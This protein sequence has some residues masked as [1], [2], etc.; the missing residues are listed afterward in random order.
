MTSHAVAATRGRSG[1]DGE[2]KFA[3]KPPVRLVC[4]DVGV[5]EEASEAA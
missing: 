1:L 5:S 3:Q 4:P 2:R